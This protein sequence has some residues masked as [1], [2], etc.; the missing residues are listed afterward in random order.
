MHNFNNMSSKYKLG[1]ILLILLI[2]FLSGIL[3]WVLFI[4]AEVS[5]LT[6]EFWYGES[7]KI[8][9]ITILM[10]EILALYLLSQV[11]QIIVEKDKIIFR[12]LILP[13]IKKEKLFSYYDYSK[14]V[15]QHTKTGTY[16]ALWLIRNEKVVDE[17]SS[18]HYSNYTKLKFEIKV[19]HS[20]KLKIG[21]FAQ[22]FCRLG[23]R[24]I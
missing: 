18:F 1:S 15:E 16:E 14:I 10:L 2:N 4:K 24:R 6:K 17:I 19:K 23:I 8:A 9:G 3:F 22:L 7:S 12:N 20:G 5:P 13:F 21:S 11:K